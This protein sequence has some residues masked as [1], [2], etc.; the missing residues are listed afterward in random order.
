[1]VVEADESDGT[2]VTLP[3]AAAIVTNIEP[4]HLEHWGGFDNLRAS[5]VRFVTE[6]DGPVVMGADDPIAA[7]LAAETGAIT[8]GVVEGADYRMGPVARSR[9]G[10]AFSFSQRGIE[11]GEI[12]VP[13]AGEYNAR[14][15]AAAAAMAL[16]L[17]APFAA[18]QAAMARFAGVARRFQYRG[19]V[20][21]VTFIDDYAH[22]PTEVADA[23]SAARDGEWDRVVCVF[24]PHRF[25]RT[26]ALWST[27]GDAFMAADVLVVTDV[28]ASGEAPRPGV[29]GKLIVDAV[30][31]AHPRQRV[32]YLPHRADLVAFLGHELRS[33]DLCLTLGAGDLTTLPDELIPRMEPG[34]G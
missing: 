3:R 4:D 6:T 7:E 5:F 18:A 12:K 8:F 22:L 10:T 27:F 9:A 15:A 21:G 31:D 16:E 29:S 33:G 34:A 2:F 32:V 13:V 1:M 20:R 28:Y 30:L 23:L 17:G 11:L 26:A 14:N 25:S 19:E 24:Q